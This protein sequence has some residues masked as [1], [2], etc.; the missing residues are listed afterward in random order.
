MIFLSIAV[1]SWAAAL[2]A[3]DRRHWRRGYATALAA[4]AGSFVL[5]ELFTAGGFWSYRSQLLPAL[6]PNLVLNLSLY[7]AGAWV[8]VQRYPYGPWR[9]VGWVLLG[10]A[11]LLAVEAVLD[12]TGH[13]FYHHGWSF[14]ASALAN[15]VLLL[16]L[17]AHDRLASGPLS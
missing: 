13:M 4:S 7:P 15:V 3:L 8:F 1:I 6:W 11:L 10:T 12:W 17:R 5:D 2:A 16:A 9:R 14:Q